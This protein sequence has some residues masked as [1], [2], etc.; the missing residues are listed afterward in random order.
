MSDNLD[1]AGKKGPYEAPALTCHGDAKAV[2]LT[3][4]QNKNKNDSVSGQNNLKT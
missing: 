1:K 3:V 4:N 2:T